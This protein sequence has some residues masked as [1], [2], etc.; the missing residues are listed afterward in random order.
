M[1]ENITFKKKL[2][3]IAKARDRVPELIAIDWS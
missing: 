2:F 3:Y 1:G